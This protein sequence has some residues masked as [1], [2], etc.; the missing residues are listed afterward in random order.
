MAVDIHPAATALEI[1]RPFRWTPLNAAARTAINLAATYA[2]D[3]GCLAWQQDDN[4]VWTAIAAG[5]GPSKWAQIGASAALPNVIHWRP[6]GAGNATTWADVMALITVMQPGATIYIDQVTTYAIPPGAPGPAVLYDMKQARFVAPPGPHDT[7]LV[8]IQRFAVLYNLY[9]HGG[10][11]RLQHNHQIADGV[12][13]PLTFPTGITPVYVVSDGA[14]MTGLANAELPMI[15]VTT[16]NPEMYLVFKDT[17]TAHYDGSGGSPPSATVYVDTGAILQIIVLSGG[18]G[19][20][21]LQ[22]PGWIGSSND[23]GIVTWIHDGSMNFPE[24]FWTGYHPNNTGQNYNFPLGQNGGM[25][26]FAYRPLYQGGGPPSVG[27]IYYNT[28]DG[29]EFYSGATYGWLSMCGRFVEHVAAVVGNQ[30]DWAP[31]TW[32]KN[33]VVYVSATGAIDVTGFAAPVASDY[34]FAKYPQFRKTLIN[35]G[36]FNMTLKNLSGSSLAA[37]QLLIA[38]GDFVVVPDGSA[39][40]EYDFSSTKWRVV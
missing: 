10:G 26:P 33:T 1:H 31:G 9:G 23:G 22:Q 29:F 16:D 35:E 36:A 25:G 24:N 39:D 15:E 4:T 12:G 7:I 20:D 34:A 27:C 8:Q 38:G 21:E 13:S 6:D 19:I 2:D 3:L 11:M 40:L 32:A 18:L 30:D 5:T 14:A 28:D 17:G 37:N